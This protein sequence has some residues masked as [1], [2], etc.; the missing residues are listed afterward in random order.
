MHSH[1]CSKKRPRISSSLCASLVGCSMLL[2]TPMGFAQNQDGNSQGNGATASPIKHVI[3]IVGENRSFDHIYATYVPH[4]HGETVQNLLSEG[5]VNADGTPGPNFAQA[6]QFQVTTPP[7][8]AKYFVNASDSEK[9]LY[10]ALPPSLSSCRFRAATPACP[11]LIN[12]CL[13]LGAQA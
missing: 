5:I 6:H 2:N 13:A 10:A 3:I 8:G 11:Q 4:N 12:S 1:S 7:N 9:T